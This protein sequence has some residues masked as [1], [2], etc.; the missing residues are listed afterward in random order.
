MSWEVILT[1]LLSGAAVSLIAWLFIAATYKEKMDI[2][3]IKS[4][5][6]RLMEFKNWATKFIDSQLFQ[7]KSPLSL[8][9]EGVKLVKDSGFEK[10]FET[11]KD[12]LANKLLEERNP[13]TK[14]DV[15]EYARG[16]MDDFSRKKYAPFLPIKTYAF[17]KGMDYAQIL[18][19]GSILLRDHYLLIHP[20]IKN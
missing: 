1:G 6:D 3:S 10:I 17:E 16:F 7:A 19:A 9:A 12:E 5:V 14:Y 18:R 2:Q 11:V 15:Q 4:N 8:T 20:E 13:Q